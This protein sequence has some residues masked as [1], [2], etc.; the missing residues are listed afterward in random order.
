M[1]LHQRGV[2]VKKI[3]AIVRPFELDE[4]K[5]ALIEIGV[6][7][8]TVSEVR[9]FGRGQGG[10]EVYRGVEYTV[11][12]LPR[13]KLESVIRDDQVGDVVAAIQRTGGT[14]HTGDGRILVLPVAEVVPAHTGRPEAPRAVRRDRR[15][16]ALGPTRP[17]R[18]VGSSP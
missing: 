15:G 6:E 14:G 13:V 16:G 9:A 11:D 10:T 18:L 4:V 7:A 12:L 3:E 5:A 1:P 8:M 2:G 17:G